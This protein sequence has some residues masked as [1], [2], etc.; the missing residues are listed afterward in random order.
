MTITN[1][2]WSIE[3]IKAVIF[4]KDGTIIDS[5]EYW[6]NIIRIRANEL[7]KQYGLAPSLYD[8]L[9]DAMGLNLITNKLKEE[10]PIALVSRDKVI[11]AVVVFLNKR[12]CSASA[13]NVANTFDYV[14]MT[15]KDSFIEHTK[16]CPD[17]EKFIKKL[18][19]AKVKMA[20]VTSDSV[21][22][23]NKILDFYGLSKYFDVVV[24]RETIKEPK[25]TGR[26]CLYALEH[27][28]VDSINTV[29]IGDAPVDVTCGVQGIGVATGQTPAS[30]LITVT[31]YV[32]NTMEELL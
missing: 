4:D 16:L 12:G 1:G 23:T 9:C 11:Q 7:I 31:P 24:G 6:G 27:L 26:P 17:V 28:G 5:H 2:F 13:T 3:N 15:Y 19:K 8:G 14:Q 32:I 18:S 30:K 10:G 20:V 21:D 29:S 22:S 25:E